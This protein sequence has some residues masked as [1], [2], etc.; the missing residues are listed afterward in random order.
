MKHTA[1]SFIIAFLALLGAILLS[2]I[3]GS[4]F[5]APDELLGAL[6]DGLTGRQPASPQAQTISTIL[7]SLRLPRTI[8]IA[9]IGAALAGSGAA[10][11]GLFRNP[12]ADPYLIGVA[13]GAGLGA[14]IAMSFKWPYS[15]VG[16]LAIPVAAFITGL[17][18]V[19]LAY[20]LARSGRSLPVANLILAG[21][22][23]SSFA[24]ALTSF[25]MLNATGELRRAL[26]WLLGGSTL[27]GWQPVVALLPYWVIG[28][29]TLMTTG[30]A[31]NVLQFGDEQAQQLGLPVDRVRR[32][33]IVSA[34]LSTAAA[35]A[36]AGIVG[37]VG[38]IVP[39]L[40]RFLIGG[41]YRR[42]LPL[43]LVVGAAFLLFADVLA[44]VVMAP[45]EL[46]V[47]VVTALAGAPFFLWLLRRTHKK[48]FWG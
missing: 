27:S 45:Q 15:T 37:F 11:Q 7:Y 28:V 41:D 12:L 3:V 33:I 18:T 4:V 5:L 36:F 39:H 9:M 30:H 17:L 23:I 13:S 26:V 42:L 48:Q 34:S 1:R 19:F 16:L 31:L 43:S 25:L 32:I 40:L 14:V 20:E 22:A 44:R 10:Y 35:V 38:L 47:G 46:P 24:T 29:G 6:A 21:V 2:I 8:L